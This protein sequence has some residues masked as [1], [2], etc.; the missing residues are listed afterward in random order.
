[1]KSD[2]LSEI[3]ENLI[4]VQNELDII[5]GDGV[6]DIS[7]EIKELVEV[8]ENI[9]KDVKHKVELT[10]QKCQEAVGK[11]AAP[12]TGTPYIC[13]P[14]LFCEALREVDMEEIITL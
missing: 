9:A 14:R 3:I 8:K 6:V 1:M 5:L 11:T 7:K 13:G 2:K 10:M 4:E 12:I